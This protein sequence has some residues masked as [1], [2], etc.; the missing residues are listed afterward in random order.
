MISL[1]RKLLC[2]LTSEEL[3]EAM[4][5]SRAAHLNRDTSVE[6]RPVDLAEC[7]AAMGVL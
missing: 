4:T 3:W 7:W 5:Q 1:D 6:R 2:A